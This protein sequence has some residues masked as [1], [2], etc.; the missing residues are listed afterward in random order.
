M[1]NVV[2]LPDG[3]MGQ[4]LEDGTVNYVGPKPLVAYEEAGSAEGRIHQDYN[5][6]VFGTVGT[7]EAIAARDKAIAEEH[8]RAPQFT[9]DRW[10]VTR[11]Y[12]PSTGQFDSIPA[13]S[14]AAQAGPPV[15]PPVGPQVD[16]QADSQVWP[17]VPF[18]REVTQNNLEVEPRPIDPAEYVTYDQAI[19]PMPARYP[20]EPDHV[21]DARARE[22]LQARN[23]YKR[24]ESAR[25]RAA[26]AELSVENRAFA[27]TKNLAN[28]IVRL[29]NNQSGLTAIV[30]EYGRVGRAFTGVGD[31]V[32]GMI[33]GVDQQRDRANALADIEALK[34][35]LLVE[36]LDLM[37]GP[38]TDKD[39]EVLLDSATSLGN[40]KQTHEAFNRELDRV[41]NTIR[42]GIRES[43]TQGRITAAQASEMLQIFSLLGQQPT[44]DQRSMSTTWGRDAFDPDNPDQAKP[45]GY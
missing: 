41:L 20:D 12:N 37:T 42:D 30:G 26:Q 21:Y 25:V 6:G 28:T 45:P 7:P 39:L 4:I 5:R 43:A 22:D 38:L 16:P 34:G 13:A 15:V 23:A 2:T 17:G 8:Y 18:R 19:G 27:K 32:A 33:P 29:R 35:M 9:E 36:E 1:T 31:F 10:G 44:Q 14:S 24:A 40:T 11:V 3:R